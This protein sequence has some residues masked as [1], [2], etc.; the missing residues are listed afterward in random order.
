MFSH[1]D[2]TQVFYFNKICLME[3][4][5]GLSH[6]EVLE[7]EKKGQT[8]FHKSVK[9]KSYGRIILDAFINP[10]NIVLFALA[11][12]FLCFQIFY[13]NGF[14]AIPITKYGFMLVILC[15]AVIS[16]ISEVSS[17][18]VVE[19][20]KLI[21]DPRVKVIRD[22]VE[23]TILSDNVVID[24]VIVLKAGDVATCDMQV[25]EGTFRVNE[26]NL[27]GESDLI[28][29]NPGDEIDSS[30]LIVSGNG[31]LIAIRVGEETFSAKIENKV[32]SIKKQNSILVKEINWM[33]NLL[34]LFTIPCVLCSVLKTWS[35][36]V[37]GKAWEFSLDV[38]TKGATTLVGMLTIGMLF[39]TSVTL[40]KA[41]V[42]LSKQNT[43]IQNLYA[44]EKLSRVDTLCLDKTGTLTSGKFYVDSVVEFNKVDEEIMK[45]FLSA[46]KERNF[47]NDALVAKYGELQSD[48]IESVHE[49]NSK[50]KY[51]SVKFKNGDEYFMGAADIL[52]EEGKEL[53][54]L[55]KKA[56]E[57]FMVIVL[58]K[59]N[60]VLQGFCLKDEL[61]S[62]IKDT[63]NYFNN[64][65]IN[66]KIISGDNL[67]AV[68]KIAKEAGV[69]NAEKGILMKGVSL[70]DIP[71]I[72][73]EYT[74]FARATPEQKEAIIKALQEKKHIVGYVGDGIND[75]TSLR[76]S[77]CAIT[78]KS[79]VDSAKS[80]ADVILLDDDF[81]HMPKVF[82]EG[83]RV[84]SNII[85]SL[86]LFM[87]KSFF[88]GLF[89]IFSVFVPNGMV[90]E[91]ESIYIYEF[92]SISL[93]GLLLSLQNNRPQKIDTNFKKKVL[94]SGFVNG[95]FMAL[96]SFVPIII[97]VT[98]SLA[99][100][101]FVTSILITISGT[102][103]MVFLCVPFEKYTTFV[104][105]IGSFATVL[106]GLML[107]DVFFKSGYL[108]GAGNIGA[109]LE[110]IGKD[111]FNMSTYSSLTSIEIW[112]LVICF[113]G[114]PI[115]YFAIYYLKS[116][117]FKKI[118]L[119][120]AKNAE[121]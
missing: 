66:V 48:E 77:N 58:K 97:N 40:S 32:S 120:E 100:V 94:L 17:K 112:V 74:V 50:D 5:K 65:N 92:I 90:I 7:R 56:S 10:F 13:P 89:S 86:T 79:A 84:V 85:R 107:P 114:G 76:R 68:Q 72:V 47:I 57:G 111:F 104:A 59:N 22:G 19:K 91:I 3:N 23:Q 73:D 33:I 42:K 26:S 31:K 41:I 25:L 4:I 45:K 93:C 39:L 117:L 46:F 44:V 98:T 18:K 60:E 80:V 63:L 20:M 69:L 55:R 75:V 54:C 116:K 109:Q 27:T 102:I 71:N 115:V 83:Q 105:L 113:V 70:E 34:L 37:D 64:I 95:L 43:M 87:S 121:R 82:E 14:K 15:N 119:K 96:I 21:T 6:E 81:A 52:L 1:I 61:R 2:C 16:I 29:K 8:N 38:I 30:S 36:G 51:S 62:N 78:F 49:F 67:E 101:S 108:K 24:D 35:I 12:V 110:L 118:D 53:D 9:G 88:L 11:I 106:F 103:V 99:N 28:E